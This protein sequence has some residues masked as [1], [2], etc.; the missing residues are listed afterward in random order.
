[1]RHVF[2]HREE[3]RAKGKAARRFIEA[4]FSPEKVARHLRDMIEGLQVRAAK[5]FLERSH[6]L[7][8]QA[9]S[10]LVKGKESIV[11]ATGDTQ[12][13]TRWFQQRTSLG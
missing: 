6:E 7:V 10:D 2:T 13:I 12:R 3:A 1:M 9:E 5:R 8:A 4:H 11:R